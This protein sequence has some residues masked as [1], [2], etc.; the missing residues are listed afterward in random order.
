M[1]AA[2]RYLLAVTLLAF[3]TPVTAVEPQRAI[4]GAIQLFEAA[5]PQLPRGLHGV[6]LGRYQAA[7]TQGEGVALVTGADPADRCARFA[8]YALLPPHNGVVQLVFCPRFHTG[9]NDALRALTVLHEMVH[10]VAGPDECR[11]MAF[12]AAVEQAAGGTYTPVGAY[13]RANGCDESRFR[14]PR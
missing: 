14:L 1:Q 4:S 6:D 8:A 2:M 3:I 5:A 11:A 9:G 10:V 7:L 13:W 12:A